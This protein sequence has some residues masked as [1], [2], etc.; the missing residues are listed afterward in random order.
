MA[1]KYRVITLMI[2]TPLILLIMGACSTKPPP[3]S[4]PSPG[5]QGSYAPIPGIDSTIVVLADSLAEDLF[6]SFEEER[7]ADELLEKGK[8]ELAASDTLFSLKKF[9]DLARDSSVIVTAEDSSKAIEYFNK[10][11]D[12]Y[13]SAEKLFERYRQDESSESLAQKLTDHLMNSRQAT[14]KSIENNPFDIDSMWLLSAIYRYLAVVF[15]EQENHLYAI[16]VLKELISMDR[17]DHSL[18]YELGYNYFQIEEWDDALTNFQKAEDFLYENATIDFERYESGSNPGSAPG[19]S[20]GV[21]SP[22]PVDTSSLFG[23]VSGQSECLTKLYRSEEALRQF[24]RALSL[25]R[26]QDERQHIL[27]RIEWIR[28]DD[29]D[30]SNVEM[31]DSLNTLERNKEYE[32]TYDGYLE[33]LPALS[34]RSAIDEVEW[35]IATIDYAILLNKEAGVE[36]M[37][38]VINRTDRNPVSSENGSLYTTF[39]EDYGTMC[40]NLAMDYLSEKKD[41][42][43]AFAYLLQASEIN[44]EKRGTCFVELMKVARNDPNK[45]IEFGEQA[46]KTDLLHDEKLLVYKQ[47]VNAYKRKGSKQDFDKAR[48]YFN[49][50][51][52]LTKE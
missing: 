8:R 1:S 28:W 49:K 18:Y 21:F 17:G 20:P 13:E 9:T 46:L 10:A 48:D 11:Y 45:L 2:I 3:A 24:D 38:K 43:K 42:K 15:E 23:Y 29:G 41:R 25:S 27:E 19:D 5:Y 44:W 16:S 39:N 12:D 35:K 32:K 31:R 14:L 33:L 30:I 36:R 40:Y 6:V 50:W 47:L 4:I 7:E 34:R 51:K 52:E 37:R 26:A 22:A